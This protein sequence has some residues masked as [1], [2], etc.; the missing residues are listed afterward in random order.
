MRETTGL[1]KV[2]GRAAHDR[3]GL[4]VF[5]KALRGVVL[6]GLA[7]VAACDPNVLIGERWNVVAGAAGQV[8]VAGTTAV[9]GGGSSAGTEASV[10]GTTEA[11][12]AAVAG[13]AG[14]TGEAGAGGAP[15]V[16][17]EWCATAPWTNSPVTF[18]S[19]VGNVIPAGNYVVT[20]KGGAQIHDGSIGYEVTDH[21]VVSKTGM[22]AG[23]HIFSG[24][25]PETGA[26][27]LWLDDTGLVFGGTIAHIEATNFE[28]TWPL[29]HH[30]GELAIT[31]Y[32]DIYDDNLGP[33]TKFCISLAKP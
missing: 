25:S 21:Y 3:L 11:G 15:A 19:D 7:A 23:H 16:E 6:G 1:A 13:A 30:G 31:L 5:P 27:H 32:D 18:T 14:V 20:Y 26:T 10:A 29:E 2:M 22:P 12:D 33:G 9:G 8:S 24:T 17:P 4:V 28:H